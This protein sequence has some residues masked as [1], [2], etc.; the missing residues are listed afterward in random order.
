MFAELIR[1]RYNHFYNL[2]KG[3]KLRYKIVI[4]M[5]NVLKIYFIKII[6]IINCVINTASNSVLSHKLFLLKRK[7]FKQYLAMD[8]S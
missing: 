7:Y 5:Y 2:C 1:E 3:Y 8:N 4:H 6:R